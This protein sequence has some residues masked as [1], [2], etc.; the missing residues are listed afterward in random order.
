MRGV[1]QRVEKEEDIAAGSRYAFREE[2]GRTEK[3]EEKRLLCQR[4]LKAAVL[5]M[6]DDVFQELCDFVHLLDTYRGGQC[7]L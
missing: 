5:W 7:P 2:G 4:V 1:G 6:G 3:G